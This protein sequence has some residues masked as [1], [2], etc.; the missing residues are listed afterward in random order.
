M[1]SA[2]HYQKRK[3]GLQKRLLNECGKVLQVKVGELKLKGAFLIAKCLP[4]LTVFYKKCNYYTAAE[5]FR[6][7][8]KEDGLVVLQGQNLKMQDVERLH[9]SKAEEET[10]IF[11]AKENYNSLITNFYPKKFLVLSQ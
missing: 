2:T 10:P 8:Q 4:A 7:I 1:I 9:E 5:P 3:A 6:G 11:V